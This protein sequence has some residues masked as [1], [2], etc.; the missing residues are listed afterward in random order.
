MCRFG[1]IIRCI[2]WIRKVVCFRIVGKLKVNKLVYWMVVIVKK[3]V[4]ILI[5]VENYWVRIFVSII[6][7]VMSGL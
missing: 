5:V 1:V 6:W 7:I 4:G 3:C 2:W